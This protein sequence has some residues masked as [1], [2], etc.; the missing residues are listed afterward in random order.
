MY[1]QWIADYLIRI[2]I[3]IPSICI[4][5]QQL[6]LKSD[7]QY[8]QKMLNITCQPGLSLNL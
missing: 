3:Y 4:I 1:L 7:D 2:L 6:Q 5:S 8:E